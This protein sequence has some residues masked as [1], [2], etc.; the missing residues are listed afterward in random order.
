[1]VII[2]FCIIIVNYL[3]EAFFF[4][5]WHKFGLGFFIK[6]SLDVIIFSFLA[7]KA[8]L[9]AVENCTYQKERTGAI[10]PL[11]LTKNG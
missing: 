9:S 11:F 10:V 8:V 2:T 7:S 4:F 3:V 6:S 1:M 5:F